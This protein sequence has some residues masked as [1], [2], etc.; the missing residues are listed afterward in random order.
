VGRLVLIV[1]GCGVWVCCFVLV[2]V[3]C[4]LGGGG[5][6]EAVFETLGG[7]DEPLDKLGSGA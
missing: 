1:W 6:G 5:E 4:L 7:V 3:G 2:G